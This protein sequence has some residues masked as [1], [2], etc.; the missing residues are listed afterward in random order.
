M[1]L[2]YKDFV[3][4]CRSCEE[5][6]WL[7]KKKCGNCGAEGQL[8]SLDRAVKETGKVGKIFS[9]IGGVVAVAGMLVVPFFGIMPGLAICGISAKITSNAK[10]AKESRL[11]EKSELMFNSLEVVE[12][13]NGINEAE[14]DEQ[15]VSYFK[16]AKEKGYSILQ[17]SFNLAKDY[18]EMKEYN[19]AISIL[20][21]LNLRSPEI[22][23]ASALLARA[24]LNSG[25]LNKERVSYIT[26]IRDCSYKDI[27]DNLTL[28]L[29]DLICKGDENTE[30]I[31]KAEVLDE[32]ISLKPNNPIYIETGA[33]LMLEAGEVRT[34]I[35]YFSR[36]DIKDLSDKAVNLYADALCMED[37][38]SE[39]AVAVYKRALSINPN[40]DAVL[41]KLCETLLKQGKYL[42]TIEFCKRGLSREHY[43]LNL[44]QILAL[45]YMKTDQLEQAILELQA[46]RKKDV[47]QSLSS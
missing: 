2:T 32:A 5:V 25:E 41:V 31:N 7:S 12:V 11:K 38:L 24:Y 43:N 47:F 22:N 28:A 26:T 19:K 34:A 35:E 42:E 29:A 10:K 8:I 6:T 4:V 17:A 1:A 40:N 37:D 18:F 44:R 33:E 36:I 46:I 21:K 39:K 14:E 20:E 45:A 16:S 23:D 30:H 9:L 3:V 15:A 27:R 13:Y